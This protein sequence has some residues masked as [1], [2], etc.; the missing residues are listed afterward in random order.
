MTKA[1]TQ[2]S[3]TNGKN[4]REKTTKIYFNVIL[5][6]ILYMEGIEKEWW[7]FVQNQL[8]LIQFA[9]NLLTKLEWFSSKVIFLTLRY[10]KYRDE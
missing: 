1:S 6:A 3:D 4:G 10:K 7:R 5:R 8:D 2:L 9:K